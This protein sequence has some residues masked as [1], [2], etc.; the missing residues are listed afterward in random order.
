MQSESTDS[1][2]YLIDTLEAERVLLEQ[3]GYQDAVRFLPPLFQNYFRFS[4]KYEQKIDYFKN[5]LKDTSNQSLALYNM[6]HYY[7]AENIPKELISY[8]TRDN[9]IDHHPIK[10]L[11]LYKK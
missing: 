10:K 11:K 4:L 3:N 2:G 8:L 6:M 7:G 1:L 9:L 5:A